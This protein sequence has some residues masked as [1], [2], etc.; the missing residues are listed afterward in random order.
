MG[1][2]I[3]HR[4]ADAG[5]DVLV[6][7]RSAATR[8]SLAAEGLPVTDEIADVAG[9]SDAVLVCVYT[10]DQ[11]REVCLEGGLLEAM[12]Q[13]SVVI[14]HTTGSPR[15]AETIAERGASR[16]I[17]VID[18]PL[19]GGPPDVAA[20]KV[21]LYVGGASGAVE[22]MRPVLGCYGDPV[23]HA[24]PLG[25]GQRVKLVNNAL[26]TAQIGLLREAVRLGAQLSLDEGTLLASLPHGSA[27][28]RAATFA[29]AKGSVAA[30]AESVGEFV[31]KDVAVVRKVAAE[32][33]ADLG[34][35]DKA[36]DAMAGAT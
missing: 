26:F 30:V 9:G 20:G 2:P 13:G 22:R 34:A 29:A 14:V 16:G 3:A 11:V 28:S 23:V 33:G 1:K 8:A 19:S 21:T 36:I 4:I 10:D 27:A 12:P 7:G 17:D 18:S 6:L 5:H 32:L 35:L 31:D 15:T 24:G 25:A